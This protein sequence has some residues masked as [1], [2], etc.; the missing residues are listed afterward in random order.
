MDNNLTLS[1]LRTYLD[2]L[3]EVTMKNEPYT[4]DYKQGVVRTE[5]GNYSIVIPEEI[6]NSIKIEE[7]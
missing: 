7:I 6:L 3:I 1:D 5:H 2:R 4:T